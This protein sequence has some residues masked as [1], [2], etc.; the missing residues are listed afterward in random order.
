MM[1]RIWLEIG[2]WIYCVELMKINYFGLPAVRN[3]LFREKLDM[4]VQ[5]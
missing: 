3:L 5:P 1:K 2:T 4:F